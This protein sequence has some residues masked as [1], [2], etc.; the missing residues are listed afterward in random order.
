M[1]LEVGEQ[2][3]VG[4]YIPRNKPAIPIAG[5]RGPVWE[6]Q[7]A[8]KNGSREQKV[9]GHRGLPGHSTAGKERL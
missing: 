7:P 6:S 1:P 3:E 8:K 9:F 2:G 5:R 4:P